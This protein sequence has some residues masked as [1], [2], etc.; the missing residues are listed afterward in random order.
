MC[1][2]ARWLRR[3][4]PALV[5]LA[6][7]L[8]VV[9]LIYAADV[10]LALHRTPSNRFRYHAIPV[11]VSRVYHNWPHDYTASRNV[12]MQ[13]QNYRRG[14]VGLLRESVDPPY[15]VGTGVYFWVA[16][17]RGLADYVAASFQLFGPRLRSLSK[18]YFVLLTSSL[19]LYAVGYWRLP[20]ALV[21]PVAILSA[22]LV[23]IQVMRFPPDVSFRHWT[24]GTEL[25]LWGEDA[26]LYESRMFDVLGLLAVA[27]LMILAAAPR[28]PRAAWVAAVPQAALLIFL[29]HARSSL[30]WQ[31]LALFSAAGVRVVWFLCRRCPRDAVRPLYVAALLGASLAGL[32]QYQR[33]TFHP[34]YFEEHGRRTFWHNALMGLHHH[35]TLRAELPME[36]CIDKD[37]IDVVLKW[38]EAREP[39]LDRNLWNSQAVLNSLGNQNEFDW[40]RYEAAARELYFELW[41]E[42]PGQ[43]LACHAVYKPL[44]V[45]KQFVFALR[46]IWARFVR[47]GA[48]ELLPAAAVLLGALVLVYRRGLRDEGIREGVAAATRTVL[49]LLPFSLIPSVAFYPVIPTTACCFVGVLALPGLVTLR[50]GWWLV[51]RVP[52]AASRPPAKPQAARGEYRS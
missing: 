29:Y 50:V 25:C 33:A 34:R 40:P 12:A 48:P 44:D 43:M 23:V 36:M 31:Y 4:G 28:V 32:H 35:P 15:P 8:A 47:G 20:G 2:C 18:F 22:W 30:G 38:M 26:T 21:L 10:R 46:L 42:R 24:W 45:G 13:F 52:L 27:H 11:A 37:A 14:V 5:L 6:A 16:D 17:D 51:L 9:G 41:R 19:L 3:N 49:V 1:A 39:G 7:A